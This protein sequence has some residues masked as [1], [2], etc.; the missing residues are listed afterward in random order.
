MSK[1]TLTEKLL[2]RIELGRKEVAEGKVISN[3]EAKKRT[4]D[5]FKKK[6]QSLLQS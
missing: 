5:W 1:L 6:I 2:E 3:E 4:A